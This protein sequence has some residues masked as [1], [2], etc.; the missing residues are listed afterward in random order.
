MHSCY[1]YVDS[2]FEGPTPVE[3]EVAAAAVDRKKP[4]NMES[5]PSEEATLPECKRYEN[6]LF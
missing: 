2:S 1:Y 4:Q 3:P 6:D 5:N